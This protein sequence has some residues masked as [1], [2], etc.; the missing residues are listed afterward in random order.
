MIRSYV[1]VC[2]R[3]SYGLRLFYINESFIGKNIDDNNSTFVK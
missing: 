2:R 3:R 1:Y